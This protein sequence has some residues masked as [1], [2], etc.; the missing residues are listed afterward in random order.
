MRTPGLIRIPSYSN[1][2]SFFGQG[3]Q[4]AKR[5]R[6]GKKPAS[7]SALYLIPKDVYSCYT[8]GV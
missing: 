7:N 2:Y 5:V 6:S 1:A 8:N 3:S 4:V